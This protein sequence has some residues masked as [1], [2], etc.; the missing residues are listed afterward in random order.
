MPLEAGRIFIPDE[1]L[2]ERFLAATGPGGQNVNK[3]ATAVQLRCDSRVI[4]MPDYA[5]EQLRT[6]AGRRMTTGGEILIVANRFRTQEANRQDARER[7]VE[8]FAK[9]ME[10]DAPRRP[11]RPTRASQ[12]R[13]MDS[14]SVRSG[15][16]KGRG[17][18]TMD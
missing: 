12:R 14:K 17:R 4:A 13:R 10:R 11:T 15:V 2:E 18:P 6:V 8:I 3:V 7:L 16:K 1:A 5:R 9:A